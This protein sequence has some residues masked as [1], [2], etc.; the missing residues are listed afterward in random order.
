MRARAY[1]RLLNKKCD[2]LKG[3]AGVATGL[4]TGF[5]AVE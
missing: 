4:F 3:V 2:E 1:M 5:S